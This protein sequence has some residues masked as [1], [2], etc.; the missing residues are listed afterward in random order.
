MSCHVDRRERRNSSAG[1]GHSAAGGGVRDCLGGLE[2]RRCLIASSVCDIASTSSTA[3]TK[4]ANRRRS[5]LGPPPA[6]RTCLTELDRFRAATDPPSRHGGGATVGRRRGA[7]GRAGTEEPT[8]GARR[9]QRDRRGPTRRLVRA[10]RQRRVRAHFPWRA[11]PTASWKFVR[12]GCSRRALQGRHEPRVTA[13]GWS[14]GC[15]GR[16]GGC[17]RGARDHPRRRG[18]CG[19]GAPTTTWSTSPAPGSPAGSTGLLRR[20]PY[21]RMCSP[22]AATGS[23]T[24]WQAA[25]VRPPPHGPPAA[26]PPTEVCFSPK[27]PPVIGVRRRLPGFSGSCGCGC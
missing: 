8:T 13:S 12:V 4:S 22:P 19:N 1:V 6:N 27:F 18:R 15:A 10:H 24:S 5:G 25:A 21:R 16:G 7:V 9:R 3:A 17:G 23:P 26:R 2:T 11:T 14:G 20:R